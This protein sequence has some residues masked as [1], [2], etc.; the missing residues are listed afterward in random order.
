MVI[1]LFYS[2]RFEAAVGILRWICLGMTLRVITW[3]MGFIIVAKGEQNLFFLTEL[4]WALFNVGLSWLCLK[5]FDLNGVGIAFSGSY[6]FHGFLIYL[7]VQWRSGFRWSGA[8][9][10]T[11][12][13][14]LSL[15]A[16]VFCG[17]YLLPPLLAIGVGTLAVILSCVYS[18]RV[19]L[20]LIS[21]ERI[22][23]FIIKFLG[24][25]RFAVS[26]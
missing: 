7:I 12:F 6:I 19:L 9:I 15:A 3:P 8:N 20:R 26:G 22:P 18:G 21:H 25:F 16:V 17:F 23:R 10:K 5:I 4:S 14:I 24:W 11:I 1:A 2:T 13:F